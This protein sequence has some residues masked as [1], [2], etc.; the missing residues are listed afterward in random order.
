M[1][2]DKRELPLVLSLLFVILASVVFTVIYSVP[3]L[4]DKLVG[5]K[6]DVINTRTTLSAEQLLQL[7]RDVN[8]VV[9]SP[10]NNKTDVPVSSSIEIG[11][12]KDI[13]LV[14]NTWNLIGATGQISSDLNYS[15]DATK[16][17][18]DINYNQS[19]KTVNAKIKGKDHLDYNSMYF[20][21]FSSK[22]I[23]SDTYLAIKDYDLIFYTEDDP[24]NPSERDVDERDFG[25]G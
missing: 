17:D 5:T 19:T 22:N 13:G 12:D 8:V 7:N 6:A 21:R 16:L 11:L 14:E 23:S 4:R 20:L 10:I 15:N 9:T 2:K 24:I 25:K 18:L 3:S 1:F